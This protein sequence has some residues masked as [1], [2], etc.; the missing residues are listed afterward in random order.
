MSY[1]LL[2]LL[3]ALDFGILLVSAED[4]D[5]DEYFETAA[6]LHRNMSAEAVTKSI[7][8]HVSS[9]RTS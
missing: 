4:T 3:F 2:T 1:V 9:A 5:W 6:L 7:K 8:E